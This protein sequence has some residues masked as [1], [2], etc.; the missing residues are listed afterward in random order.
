MRNKDRF[1]GCLLAGAAGDALGFEVKFMSEE[2]IF[3]KYR[4]TVLQNTFFT[5]V[6]RKYLMIHRWLYSLRQA[7]CSGRL[8]E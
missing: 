6:L 2:D 3:S 1:F 8:E 7:S 4:D 5:M